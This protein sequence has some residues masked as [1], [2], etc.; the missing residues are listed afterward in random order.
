MFS[1]IGLGSFKLL[2]ILFLPF[3]IALFA[4]WIWALVDCIRNRR[5][6]D[7]ERI[8]WTLVI[9]FLHALGAILYL[10]AGRKAAA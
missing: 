1:V 5:L 6:S 2:F 3:G 8:A 7:G 10:I 4:F 9:V